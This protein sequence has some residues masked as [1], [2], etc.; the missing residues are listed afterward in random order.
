VEKGDS[1]HR[2]L[3]DLTDLRERQLPSSRRKGKGEGGKEGEGEGD[4]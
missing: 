1:S 2:K 3:L 4:M